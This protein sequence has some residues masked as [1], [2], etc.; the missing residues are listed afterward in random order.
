MAT[1]TKIIPTSVTLHVYTSSAEGEVMYVIDLGSPKGTYG[2]GLAL[3]MVPPI[4]SSRDFGQPIPG[5]P[6]PS[7]LPVVGALPKGFNKVMLR[8]E[9]QHP[10]M[11]ADGQHVAVRLVYRS[12]PRPSI[13]FDS[14]LTQTIVTNYLDEAS[15]PKKPVFRQMIL[16]TNKTIGNLF[17]TITQVNNLPL[18]NLPYSAPVL[19]LGSSIRVSSVYYGDSPSLADAVEKFPKYANCYNKGKFIFNNDEQRWLCT[20]ASIDT[21]DQWHFTFSMEVVYNP[22][23]WDTIAT[24]TDQFSG[25]PATLSQD[26]IDSTMDRR[27]AAYDGGPPKS[28][29][30]GNGVARF[31]QHYLAELTAVFIIISTQD[32]LRKLP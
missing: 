28:F 8:C 19:Q 9:E 12:L 25:I 13:S 16:T 22:L 24:Y 5:A 11:Q 7:A 1:E 6:N 30:T 27:F 14:A 17:P 26:D 4:G 2:I 18:P 20:K 23:G 29:T 3:D 10:T 32:F 21:I 31:S 15:T